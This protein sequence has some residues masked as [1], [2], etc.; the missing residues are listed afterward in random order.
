MSCD[1]R[2]THTLSLG[3]LG[4]IIMEEININI[5]MDATTKPIIRI[6][7]SMF[8]PVIII[9]EV[10]TDCEPTISIGLINDY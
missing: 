10:V 8:P 9:N 3:F 4:V 7:L 6:D 2:H 1:L 5:D